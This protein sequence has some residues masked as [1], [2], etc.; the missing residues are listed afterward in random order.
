[1]ALYLGNTY[2]G[3][4][5]I[6]E[7]VVEKDVNFYDYEGTLV[8]SYTKQE[9]LALTAL[10]LL[11]D[12][13]AENLTCDGWNWTLQEV[14]DQVTYV[15]GV[16][17]VGA[18]YHP[19]D[20]KTHIFYSAYSESK[21]ITLVITP[22]VANDVVIDWGD[23][24]SDTLANAEQT[25]TVHTYNVT[26]YTIFDI[27]ISSSNNYSIPTYIFGNQTSN[28]S[29]C[30]NEVWLSSKVSSIAA[31]SFNYF[32]YLRKL[33][34]PDNLSIENNALRNCTTLQCL[35]FRR[36]ITSLP[37]IFA[38]CFLVKLIVSGTLNYIPNN[39]ARYF[40]YGSM[41]TVPLAV[42]Y[43]GTDT[44]KGVSGTY[45]VHLGPNVATLFGGSSSLFSDG[46]VNR[47]YINRTTPP[48]LSANCIGADVKNIY[49]PSSAVNTYKS[50]T[51]WSDYASIIVAIPE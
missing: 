33:I 43:I 34:L 37:A 42:T 32:F 50:A 41:N 35:V 16:V 5:N 13:T 39:S 21:T 12:R 17:E 23:G 2:I 26:T 28:Q 14:K 31:T 27:K 45:E 29:T 38:Y 48:T 8:A 15:G 24:T 25:T 47:V 10:P 19:T 9:A 46:Q 4:C 6:N 1:M 22:S 51:N 18:L 40:S 49:V 3:S 7:R 30:V 20:N 36:T 11:P 44:Y